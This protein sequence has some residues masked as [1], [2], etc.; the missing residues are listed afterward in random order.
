MVDARTGQRLVGIERDGEGFWVFIDGRVPLG[1]VLVYED[2]NMARSI[3]HGGRRDTREGGVRGGLVSLNWYVEG[4]LPYAKLG[5]E[6]V[7]GVGGLR[8][9]DGVG[10]I[11]AGICTQAGWPDGPVSR[12]VGTTWPG[13]GIGFTRNHHA[14]NKACKCR[15]L[16]ATSFDGPSITRWAAGRGPESAGTKGKE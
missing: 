7:R 13:G 10:C 11:S 12:T 9:V 1:G 14:A 2:G 5:S 8:V 16:W 15:W 4:H 6:G 3:P